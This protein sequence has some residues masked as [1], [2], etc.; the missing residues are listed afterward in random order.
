MKPNRG[1][2]PASRPPTPPLLANALPEPTKPFAPVPNNISALIRHIGTHRV[3][4]DPRRRL[5]I[6]IINENIVNRVARLFVEW[7]ES[8]E[9]QQDGGRPAYQQRRNAEDSESLRFSIRASSSPPNGAPRNRP[10]NRAYGDGLYLFTVQPLEQRIGMDS[11]T[12][13]TPKPTKNR[14]SVVS[15]GAKRRIA[16]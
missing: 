16:R 3:H 5:N 10:K 9:A 2:Q 12:L 4:R 15:D 11:S 6:P 8:G 7:K 13:L 1:R 14:M